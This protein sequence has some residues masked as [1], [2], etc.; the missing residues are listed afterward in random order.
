MRVGALDLIPTQYDLQAM[1]LSYLQYVLQ[2]KVPVESR[3]GIKKHLL[4]IANANYLGFIRN[5]F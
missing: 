4:L 3:Q 1:N 2:Q 5:Q